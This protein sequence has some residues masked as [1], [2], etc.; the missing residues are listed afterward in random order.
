[1]RGYLALCVYVCNGALEDNHEKGCV[2]PGHPLLITL[3]LAPR[4]KRYIWANI[5]MN[6]NKFVLPPVNLET[7]N[8]ADEWKHWLEAF[9]NY[10]IATKLNKEKDNVERATLL[11]LAG[12]GVQ[13]LFSGLPGSKEKYEDVT[14]ALT[15]HFRPKKNKWAERYRFRKRAQKENETVDT[16]IAGGTESPEPFL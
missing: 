4:I 14:A 3:Q 10:R 9:G 5:R 6:F 15:A 16:F 2:N 12:T 7:T 13:R 11:H 1:M 8:L